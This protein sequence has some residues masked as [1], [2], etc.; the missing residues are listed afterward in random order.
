MTLRARCAPL[1][2]RVALAACLAVA[3]ATDAA[4]QLRRV[5]VGSDQGQAPAGIG[6]GAM[7][8]ANGRFVVFSST[9]PLTPDDTNGRRTSARSSGT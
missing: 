4:A 8:S 9:S 1:C 6:R 2:A 3:A 5:S 7:M